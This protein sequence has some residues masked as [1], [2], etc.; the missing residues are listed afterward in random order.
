MLISA[1]P[2]TTIR[3]DL[4]GPAA[5]GRSG[6]VNAPRRTARRVT[7]RLEEKSSQPCWRQGRDVSQ[8]LS[9]LSRNAFI[10]GRAVGAVASAEGAQ[11]QASHPT[12]S[13]EHSEPLRLSLA[14]LAAV[15]LGVMAV[16]KNPAK[17]A[18][19]GA[20]LVENCAAPLGLSL[21]GWVVYERGNRIE[22]QARSSQSETKT[23]FDQ[24]E[25]KIAQVET[26]LE[27]KI[28]QVETNLGAKM[29]ENQKSI[30]DLLENTVTKQT[31][32]YELQL[33]EARRSEQETQ[34]KLT[35][36]NQARK[37][38]FSRGS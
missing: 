6:K 18:A 11:H 13:S 16:S 19:L 29:E 17:L 33:V 31:L 5:W 34:L 27:A 22:D 24:L 15:A 12:P 25:A 7:Q 10:G 14:S 3:Q 32:K 21:V 38:F 20:W 8:T 35:L 37:G 28:A 9:F 26:N 23:K 30:I 36:A 4:P 1:A 2:A